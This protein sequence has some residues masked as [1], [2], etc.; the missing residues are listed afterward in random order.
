MEIEEKDKL[1]KMDE[2]IENPLGTHLFTISNL[3]VW[4]QI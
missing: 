2:D 1:E 3:I 4:E